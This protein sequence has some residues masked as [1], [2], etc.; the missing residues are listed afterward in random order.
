M[1]QRLTYANVMSTLAAFLALA[2][3]SVAIGAALSKNSV[4]SKQVKNESLT[5]KDLKNGKAVGSGEVT[6]GSLAAT[7]LG[8]GSVGSAEI[9]DGAVADADLAPVDPVHV[10]GTAGEPALGTGGEGDCLYSNAVVVPPGTVT[11][12]PVSFFKDRSGVVHLS[13][14]VVQS[15]GPGGD[16]A[17]T[18]SASAEGIEDSTIF[19]LPPGYRPANSETQATTSSSIFTIAQDRDATNIAGATLPAGSVLT[20]AGPGTYL[21][22]GI[23][24][25]AS[26]VG[27]R[28]GDRESVPQTTVPANELPGVLGR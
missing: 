27:A 7:D 20:N 23:S 12:N 3:G 15:N 26:G 1:R 19:Q 28:S 5:N 4:K 10:V 2:G 8:D 14:I 25:R 13:G 16:A 6:D 9:A 22:D 17:C 11:L 18:V 21:L 24:F